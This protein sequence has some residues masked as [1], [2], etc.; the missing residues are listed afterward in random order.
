M[1]TS[2]M[3]T[4]VGQL[5]AKT[6]V[7]AACALA[8]AFVLPV[9]SVAE[10]SR[11]SA[12]GEW[13]VFVDEEGGK[14][15]YAVS[16]PKAQSPNT[17]SWD[18]RIFIMRGAVTNGRDEPSVRAGYTYQDGSSA[19][20][21]IGS[22]TFTLFTDNDGAWV[23]DAEGERRLVAAMKGGSTMIVKGTSARGNLT[24][25]TYSLSGVTAAV[26][27]INQLCP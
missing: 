5:N 4:S 2:N 19:T 15:C 16:R 17:L 7:L 20:V 11:D 14:T 23:T 26:N 13:A 8:T 21:S 1:A 18:P 12:H 22:E 27:R 6:L 3:A 24:T 10:P 9:S 25:D